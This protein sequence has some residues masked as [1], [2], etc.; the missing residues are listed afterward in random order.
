M[1]PILI[2]EATWYFG[3][4]TFAPQ[5]TAYTHDIMCRLLEIV[6][7]VNMYDM[8]NLSLLSLSYQ[9]KE[10]L[11]LDLNITQA[12]LPCSDLHERERMM[13]EPQDP[14]PRAIFCRLLSEVSSLVPPPR[15][16]I[17]P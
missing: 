14:K 10:T 17:D 4:E 7:L 3:S 12:R 9:W 1:L 5:A 16:L 8:P 2:S 13:I 15:N 6:Q 11:L